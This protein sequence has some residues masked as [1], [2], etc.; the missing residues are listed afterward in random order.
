MVK[1][2]LG[3]EVTYSNN[4]KKAKTAVRFRQEEKENDYPFASESDAGIEKDADEADLKT[5]FIRRSKALTVAVSS[6]SP[7]LAMIE[8]LMEHGSRP[9]ETNAGKTALRHLGCNATYIDS[10]ESMRHQ[11]QAAS[12]V[13]RKLLSWVVEV[14]VMNHLH[15]RRGDVISVGSRGSSLKVKFEIPAL[16]DHDPPTTVIEH[17]TPSEVIPVYKG[18]A[19]SGLMSHLDFMHVV[20]MG[21]PD[22][23]GLMVDLESIEGYYKR[24]LPFICGD[25]LKEALLQCLQTLGPIWK[26]QNETEKEIVWEDAAECWAAP[27]QLPPPEWYVLRHLLRGLNEAHSYETHG[28]SLQQAVNELLAEEKET[29]GLIPLSLYKEAISNC[30]D[31]K[32]F[33]SELFILHQHK[34]KREL[35]ENWGKQLRGSSSI[36]DPAQYEADFAIFKSLFEH[37]KEFEGAEGTLEIAAA[38]GW[39]DAVKWLIEGKGTNANDTN[40]AN[41]PI[42]TVALEV[43]AQYQDITGENLQHFM[44]TCGE[45]SGGQ[46]IEFM[47]DRDVH[48]ARYYYA[49]SLNDTILQKCSQHPMM[50]ALVELALILFANGAD[51]DPDDFERLSQVMRLDQPFDAFIQGE[52]AD[53]VS[54]LHVAAACD[55]VNSVRWL[56]ENI[57]YRDTV[58][59]G[60]MEDKRGRTA[61]S[62]TGSHACHQVL[63]KKEQDQHAL[64][65]YMPPQEQ[66]NLVVALRVEDVFNSVAVVQNLEKFCGQDGALPIGVTTVL[67]ALNMLDL[68]G[69]VLYYQEEI[70]VVVSGTDKRQFIHADR[71]PQVR[72]CDKNVPL[73]SKE[74]HCITSR[75][76]NNFT[77]PILDL[78]LQTAVQHLE[79]SFADFRHPDNELQEWVNTRQWLNYGHEVTYPYSLKVSCRDMAYCGDYEV[80]SLIPSASPIWNQVDGP[81]VI[82]ADDE[83]KWCIFDKERPVLK[84]TTEG[85]GR[86]PAER[87]VWQAAKGET[88]WR[89]D[90][91]VFVTDGDEKRTTPSWILVDECADV[92]YALLT[93]K[94]PPNGAR[95]FD[96]TKRLIRVV[97]SLPDGC[98][99]TLF[100][101]ATAFPEIDGEY[102]REK[103]LAD[104]L[105]MVWVNANGKFKLHVTFTRSSA[106]DPEES[107]G[108]TYA[109]PDSPNPGIVSMWGISSYGGGTETT[110]LE[111]RSDDLHPWF[112]IG[113]DAPQWVNV[114]SKTKTPLI[115]FTLPEGAAGLL[116]GREMLERKTRA[117]WSLRQA[118]LASGMPRDTLPFR[119]VNRLEPDVPS[120]YMSPNLDT[121]GNL[122]PGQNWLDLLK[123]EKK[124]AQVFGVHSQSEAKE[125][126]E[127]WQPDFTKGY[128]CLFMPWL[129]QPFSCIWEFLRENPH[130]DSEK[131]YDPLSRTVCDRKTFL[132]LEPIASHTS[133]HWDVLERIQ[134]AALDTPLFRERETRYYSNSN[135]EPADMLHKGTGIIPRTYLGEWVFVEKENDEWWLPVVDDRNVTLLRE[136][137]VDKGSSCYYRAVY[138][139]TY[140]QE[141]FTKGG[142][143]ERCKGEVEPLKREQEIEVLY[144]DLEGKWARVRHHAKAV[145]FKS[146]WMP[147]R[148]Q[149]RSRRT[150][151]PFYLSQLSKLEAYLGSKVAFYFAFLATYCAYL[152]LLLMSGVCFTV[153]QFTL[154]LHQSDKIVMWNAIL[155]LFW[156][157]YFRKRWVRK[158]SELTYMWNVRNV[159]QWEP[160]MAEFLKN[161]MKRQKR[162]HPI[163]G[164]SEPYFTSA[165]RRPRLLL[166]VVV[167]SALLSGV[168]FVMYQNAILRDEYS[169][170]NQDMKLMFG[171]ENAITIAAMDVVYA[172]IAGK[173]NFYENHRTKSSKQSSA[174]LKNFVFRFINGFSGL[175]ITVIREP[176]S[177]ADC[178]KACHQ[179]LCK[180]DNPMT[181]DGGTLAGGCPTEAQLDEEISVFRKYDLMVQLTTQLIIQ[182]LIALMTEKVIPKIILNHRHKRKREAGEEVNTFPS[183][184]SCLALDTV[185]RMSEVNRVVSF[186]NRKYYLTCRGKWSVL[187]SKQYGG[188]WESEK[189]PGDLYLIRQEDTR[190]YCSVR[191]KARKCS[192]PHATKTTTSSADNEESDNEA[193]DMPSHTE[194]YFPIP[195]GPNKS[196]T[197]DIKGL[198]ST[199][200]SQ[201]TYD[202]MLVYPEPDVAGEP[203]D[204]FIIVRREEIIKGTTSPHAQV[205]L[206]VEDRRVWFFSNFQKKKGKKKKKKNSQDA[207]IPQSAV[208]FV[209]MYNISDDVDVVLGNSDD[210]VSNTIRP[211]S[212]G[213]GQV[214]V[215]KQRRRKRKDRPKDHKDLDNIPPSSPQKKHTPSRKKEPR[216]RKSSKKG[217]VV[218][219]ADAVGD[220]ENGLSSETHVAL[221]VIANG[222]YAYF[223]SYVPFFGERD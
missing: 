46:Y 207:S 54:L 94:N 190:L 37:G 117:M 199:I 131:K 84:T 137:Q 215:T 75:L 21:W 65:G 192:S 30:R 175:M 171:V 165:H 136:V 61:R 176:V 97:S 152:L 179:T 60:I 164:L 12:L 85:V 51:A 24:T 169:V 183:K 22:V 71:Y 74:K 5:S 217:H 8:L 34:L 185:S 78:K 88:M 220:S 115:C 107:V 155:V 72:F 50:Q 40:T 23:V 38:Y 173:L 1:T 113:E 126:L 36:M 116:P 219:L 55:N 91:K 20:S 212:P 150:L 28:P 211:T 174:I 95:P 99:D 66:I 186:H 35:C 184:L 154:G 111:L 76:V 142:K 3:S 158:A 216:T 83:G 119:K 196:V 106:G 121:P 87:F 79:K 221:R 178:L 98:P 26:K 58:G 32:T 197:T 181:V 9:D 108:I 10:N 172:L 151:T 200:E 53:Q 127:E 163:T 48:G 139:L 18:P 15:R 7:N 59:S 133:A 201:S 125:V 42:R 67:H 114:S 161:N 156:G 39:V 6:N 77:W 168:V 204:P 69:F 177:V 89:P 73:L 2:L 203:T 141:V 90:K 96:M 4:N 134:T 167:T 202:R 112:C 81:R 17:F 209:W 206:S 49:N 25:S 149:D 214:A 135:I 100:I 122:P 128:A 132:N 130:V 41:R 144:L 105:H 182:S 120:L 62:Y 16:Y 162:P 198:W 195:S 86:S 138:D 70:Y 188:I 160:A 159:E 45:L 63:A 33:F 123:Q 223:D 218:K 129:W 145:Y 56:L 189:T 102:T 82:R 118:L 43:S 153:V 222:A 143:E 180:I 166:S 103:T 191:A 44:D 19:S 29:L 208:S 170:V 193:I 14:A 93:D 27:E 187:R 110:H 194:V 147:L 148:T 157:A 31:D 80:D 205:N 124:I 52:V 13:L 140:C 57:A 109:R 92:V 146:Y 210:E 101:E 47:R 64:S 11:Q 104:D 68:G 213:A